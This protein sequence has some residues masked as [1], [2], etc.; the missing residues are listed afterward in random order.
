MAVETLSY[1]Q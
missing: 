1:P